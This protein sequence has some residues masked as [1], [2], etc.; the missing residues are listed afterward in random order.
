MWE[1]DHVADLDGRGKVGDPEVVALE[2]VTANWNADRAHRR[3]RYISSRLSASGH[4]GQGFTA[5]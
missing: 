1:C 5:P 4:V 2:R 3:K